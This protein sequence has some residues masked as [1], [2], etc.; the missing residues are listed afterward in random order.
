MDEL[1]P[2]EVEHLTAFA[3]HLARE[4]RLSPHTVAAYR[5]DLRDLVAE[6]E[7]RGV[8]TAGSIAPRDLARHLAG[9][10]TDKDMA[11]SSII[12]ARSPGQR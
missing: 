10:K 2:S 6:L 11:S 3:D 4:R 12:V 1:P 9:L 5:R 7:P 8:R